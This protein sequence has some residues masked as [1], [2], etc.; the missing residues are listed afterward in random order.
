MILTRNATASYSFPVLGTGRMDYGGSCA[1]TTHDWDVNSGV[2]QLRHQIEGDHLVARLV[3]SGKAN[4][5]VVV[6]MKATMY[7][8]TII[9][10][11]N[12]ELSV[13]QT[14]TIEK[15]FRSLESPKLMPMVVYR[16]EDEDFIADK[17]MGLGELWIDRK[18]KFVKGAIIARDKEHEFQP[19][20]S[21]LLRVKPDVSVPEGAIK[22]DIVGAESGYFIVKVSS[23]LFRGMRRAPA[24]SKDK[25]WHRDSILAHALSVGFAEC[26]KRHVNGD[27]EIKSLENFQTIKR[28]LEAEGVPTWENP[29]DFDPCEAAAVYQ[30][31]YLGLDENAEEEE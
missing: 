8:R 7:R 11:R 12:G 5:G 28:Q 17:S 6:V 31:H 30:R 19:G 21:K 26:A 18:F 1:Y 25:K 13:P 2:V 22:V 16:G 9:A 3:K 27:E 24:V 15:G 29:D 14:F 4:F 10:E 23:E 20:L